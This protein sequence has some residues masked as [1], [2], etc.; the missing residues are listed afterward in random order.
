MKHNGG[1]KTKTTE[2]VYKRE[3]V[4]TSLA[5]SN[6]KQPIH[7]VYVPSHLYHMLFELF[8]V[9]NLGDAPLGGWGV[10]RSRLLSL[11]LTTFPSAECHAG[12]C[13]KP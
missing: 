1:K 5:A 7:M 6:S 2:T 13:G 4:W 12:D 11:Y 10:V 8:K 3:K 9:R